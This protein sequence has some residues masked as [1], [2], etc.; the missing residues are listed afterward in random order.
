MV[1]PGTLTPHTMI[2]LVTRALC[3]QASLG[4]SLY[5]IS[6]DVWRLFKLQLSA[7]IASLVV[8]IAECKR[9][10]SDYCVEG[11]ES[12]KSIDN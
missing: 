2:A 1:N 10:Q 6:D 12:T 11:E 3:L 5:I 9:S 8:A 4:Q 7:G